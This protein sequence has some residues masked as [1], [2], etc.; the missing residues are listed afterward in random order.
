MSKAK[1]ISALLLHDSQRQPCISMSS[2][3]SGRTSRHFRCTLAAF[4]R[5]AMLV[6]E[7][8]RW[9]NALTHKLCSTHREK[10]DNRIVC[11]EGA[12]RREGR[13]YRFLFSSHFP[14]T[15]NEV[16]VI[17]EHILVSHNDQISSTHFPS[18]HRPFCLS[19]VL[20]FRCCKKKRLAFS[21]V[22]QSDIKAAIST[23]CFS[24]SHSWLHWQAPESYVVQI[25]PRMM[26]LKSPE[27]SFQVH[28]QT[29]RPCNSMCTLW[30][31]RN[32]K[33]NPSFLSLPFA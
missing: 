19:S 4:P 12:F 8:P 2:Q 13:K 7:R 31:A 18:I 30:P 1:T 27:S 33:G 6:Q 20:L 15:L 32:I 25:C 28:S 9:Y 17:C 5:R 24:P 21:K 10:N 26:G 11:S 22:H 23:S 14:L 29:T 16:R 3:P